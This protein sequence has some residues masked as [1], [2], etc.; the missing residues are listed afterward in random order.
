MK[1]GTHS[2]HTHTASPP[3]ILEHDDRSIDQPLSFISHLPMMGRWIVIVNL[4]WEWRVPEWPFTNGGSTIHT[5]KGG[6]GGVDMPIQ[7]VWWVWCCK[8]Y[9]KWSD[10]MI[11]GRVPVPVPPSH[12][13]PSVNRR[14]SF[15]HGQWSSRKKRKKKKGGG[16]HHTHTHNGYVHNQN[17][18]LSK[19]FLYSYDLGEITHLNLLTC[20]LALRC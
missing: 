13:W 17:Q 20:L 1:L 10:L 3:C 14:K 19:S 15:N 18:N 7:W 5:I 9:R 16:T 11:H 2:E 6:G 8:S 4:G 12:Q